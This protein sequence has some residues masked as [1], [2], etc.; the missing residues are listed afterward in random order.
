[1][2]S[3]VVSVGLLDPFPFPV[4]PLPFPLRLGGLSSSFLGCRRYIGLSGCRPVCSH[5]LSALGL[6]M[7]GSV[8]SERGGGSR[9]TGVTRWEFAVAFGG[10]CDVDGRTV[11]AFGFAGMIV[12]LHGGWSAAD[13]CPVRIPIHWQNGGGG[14]GGLA[15]VSRGL[16]PA[17]G[18]GGGGGDLL[19]R[20]DTFGG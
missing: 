7:I 1:M 3:G 18:F 20:A 19:W 12:F 16:S 10:A 2:L 6:R 11:S 13:L 8:V 15:R 4:R 5:A 17:F 14:G 9:V